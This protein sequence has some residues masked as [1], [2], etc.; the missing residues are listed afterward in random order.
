MKQNYHKTAFSLLELIAVIAI[1]G[2]VAAVIVSRVAG[3]TD[4]ADIAACHVY[5][6]DI[7]IQA[8]LWHHN[9]GS[10]PAAN[11][12]SIGADIDYFPEG[13]PT[14]PVD[15]TAYTIDAATGLVVGHSH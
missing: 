11:L 2:I 3:N 9:T 4:A 7:E 6:G 12:A 8:E 10:W 14:C 5:K 1:L 13:L 15:G